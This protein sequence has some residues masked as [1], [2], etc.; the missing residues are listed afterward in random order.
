MVTEGYFVEYK[1]II[2]AVK[3]C[4]HPEG[5]VVALPRKIDN[6]KVKKFSEGMEIVKKRFPSLLKFIKEIGFEVPLIPL[7]ESRIL[8]PFAVKIENKEINEFL[9]HFKNIG[10]TG[11]M[12]YE[13]IG[14]DVDLISFNGENYTILRELRNK[15]I[16]SPLFHTVPEEIEILNV[17]DFRSLKRDRV[18]EGIYKNKFPY[19]FKIVEC[20]DFGEVISQ[21]EFSGIISIDRAIKPYTIPVKYLDEKR[22]L[23]I[24]SFRVRF[25]ELKNG[26]KLYV[27]GKLLHRDKFDDLD[28]DIAEVVKILSA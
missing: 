24:T 4:F 18:L 3:G 6:L 1:G 7:E 27:K 22:N 15:G 9:S 21:E 20:E 8:D 10:I 23:I 2:W 26:M 16:T 12:L 11:S 19:T 17:E 13:G 5:Y 28:L 25:T 14:N